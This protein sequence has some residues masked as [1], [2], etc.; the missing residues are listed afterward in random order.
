MA[1]EP[2][3][4]PTTGKVRDRDAL[5]SISIGGRPGIYTRTDESSH[6]ARVERVEGRDEHGNEVRELNITP[7][8]IDFGLEGHPA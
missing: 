4:D 8:T 5:R 6:L 7:R 2:L 3:F 1:R